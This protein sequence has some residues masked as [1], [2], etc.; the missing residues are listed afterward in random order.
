MQNML[1]NTIFEKRM[2]NFFLNIAVLL[3]KMLMIYN[4]FRIIHNRNGCVQTR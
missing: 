3:T 1:K 2:T 4:D